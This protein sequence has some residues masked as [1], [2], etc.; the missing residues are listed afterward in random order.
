[1]IFGTCG[2]F[3]VCGKRRAFIA[4]GVKEKGVTDCMQKPAGRSAVMGDHGEI[5][6]M[7]ALCIDF[8]HHFWS[9]PLFFPFYFPS[10]SILVWQFEWSQEGS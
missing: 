7:H 8:A 6:K 10:L 1:M 4:G 2:I 9:F 3:G 5:L